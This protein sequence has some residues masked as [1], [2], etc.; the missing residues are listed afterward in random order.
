M[1]FGS[2]KKLF[3]FLIKFLIFIEDIKSNDFIERCQ[4]EFK[5][6]FGNQAILESDDR[7]KYISSIVHDMTRKQFI[8]REI[9][10]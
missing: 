9:I 10:L 8:E 7:R 2:C 6:Q 5:I 4:K 3:S 1:T